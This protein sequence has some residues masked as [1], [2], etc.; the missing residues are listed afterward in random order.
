MKIGII[1]HSMT[2]NTASVA[3]KLAKRLTSKGHSVTIEHV[4]VV[5]PEDPHSLQF[6]L[7][8][9][10]DASPY[11]ACCF[12]APVRGFSISPVI[13]AYLKQISP[14]G[15]KK[16]ACFVTKTLPGAW[17]GGNHAITLMK[18]LCESKGGSVEATSIVC[19]TK[20]DLAPRI[21]KAVNELS[22]IFKR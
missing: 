15:G 22:G 10:P 12:G 11:D 17:T 14:L 18:R 13:S 2:G 7:D 6:Q 19:W 21:S 8:S 9:P 20:K 1:V 5:G 16:V 4:K 3:Q